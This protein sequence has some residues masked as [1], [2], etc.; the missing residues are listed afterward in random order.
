ML[1]VVQTLHFRDV[2]VIE[3]GPA[4]VDQFVQVGE[5]GE[6]LAVKVKGCDLLRVQRSL[7]SK[8]TALVP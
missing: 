4:Q 3:G 6:P 1:A 5:P 2:V 7:L 8:Q